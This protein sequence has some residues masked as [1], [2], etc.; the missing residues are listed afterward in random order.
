MSITEKYFL[1]LSPDPS[2]EDGVGIDSFK[3]LNLVAN[4]LSSFVNCTSW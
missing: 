3:L 2:Y 4:S 1:G